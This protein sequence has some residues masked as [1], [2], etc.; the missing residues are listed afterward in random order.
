ML[1]GGPRS[2]EPSI[3]AV[4]L[5]VY[6]AVHSLSILLLI[7]IYHSVYLPFYLMSSLSIHPTV[8]SMQSISL[9]IPLSI[10]TFDHPPGFTPHPY[11]PPVHRSLR[12]VLSHSQRS[13]RD[14]TQESIPTVVVVRRRS[15]FEHRSHTI[16]TASQASL[17]QLNS[18]FF[19]SIRSFDKALLWNTIKIS[20]IR[21]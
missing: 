9:S 15:L 21:I 12:F 14:G 7:T 4:H 6:L 17:S 2:I 5:L 1:I 20:W 19:T 18:N 16:R 8:H 11:T 10:L 3:L 13:K